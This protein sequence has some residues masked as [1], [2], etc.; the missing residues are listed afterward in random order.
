MKEE[1]EDS[2]DKLFSRGLS[3]P[4]SNAQ[5]REED[6]EAMEALL[7]GKKPKAGGIVRSLIYLA[8]TIAAMLLLIIGWLY[9]N[10]ADNANTHK[11]QTA[12]KKQQVKQDSGKYGPPV[13]QLAET[14]SNTLS[15]GDSS[16]MSANGAGSKSRSFFTLSAVPGGRNTTGDNYKYVPEF[17][18]K[19]VT[20][21][22]DAAQQRIVKVDTV[23][24]DKNTPVIANSK[25]YID[26]IIA[27]KTA[28]MAA[29]NGRKDTI[30]TEK[31]PPLV[32][33]VDDIKPN[34]KQRRSG[35]GTSGPAAYAFRPTFALSLVASPDVN[36][37]RGFSDT[38]VG[39]NVG[40][41]LTLGVSRRWSI[42]TGAIYAD[43]PYMTDFANYASAYKFSTN[44]VSVTA[45]CMVLDIPINLGYQL[46]NNG[47]NKFSLGTGLSSYFMLRENYTYNY[48]GGYP[49]GPTSYNIRNKNQHILGILNLNATYQREVSSKFG[50]GVQPYFKVPLTGIGYGQVN[51]KSAG[52]A[53]G[54]TWNISTGLKP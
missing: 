22:T 43:K 31:R 52:V 53:V 38:K 21:I 15:A 20:I 19:Q 28:V 51:L 37:A 36:S 1:K 16:L 13:Q 10:P 8:G 2:I 42:S 24:T 5:Y 30:I 47:R 25:S 14:K 35:G 29:N 40:L 32:S 50:I 46:Y 18:S 23:I 27:D 11:Q 12:V 44:P 39:T 4:G 7:D 26:T 6:W 54:V 34:Q 33:V 48:A 3:E 45:S 9:I 49:A 41:M 17:K